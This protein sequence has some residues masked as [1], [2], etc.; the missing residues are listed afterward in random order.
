MLDAASRK[1]CCL[2]AGHDGLHE[3]RAPGDPQAF[4]WG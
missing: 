4:S 2:R 1:Q 3:W